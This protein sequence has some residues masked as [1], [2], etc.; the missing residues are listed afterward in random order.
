V[1]G[2]D[3]VVPLHVQDTP[4]IRFEPCWSMSVYPSCRRR[5]HETRR[6]ERAGM[7]RKMRLDP[8]GKERLGASITT[9]V[10]DDL[11]ELVLVQLAYLDDFET[12]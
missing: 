12:T 2:R 11:T 1:E 10:L 4:F 6:K 8:G 7:D 5:A 3:P 9:L